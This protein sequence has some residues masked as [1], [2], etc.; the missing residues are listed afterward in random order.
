MNLINPNISQEKNKNNKFNL[1][2]IKIIN[3]I[4]KNIKI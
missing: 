4:K 3:K 1:I 2:I